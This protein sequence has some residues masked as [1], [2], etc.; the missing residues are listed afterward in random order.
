MKGLIVIC[1]IVNLS[2]DIG[3]IAKCVKILIYALNAIEKPFI[4]MISVSSNNL[5]KNKNKSDR[6]MLESI[7]DLKIS[8][9]H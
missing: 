7:K 1:A 2:K 6:P 8:E 3:I 5:K 9:N 4:N